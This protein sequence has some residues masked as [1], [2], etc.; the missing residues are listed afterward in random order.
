[1][2]GGGCWLLWDVT[3]I[4][5]SGCWLHP[6]VVG[7][8]AAWQSV[9]LRGDTAL[10]IGIV[11]LERVWYFSLAAVEK[12]FL[13]VVALNLSGAVYEARETLPTVDLTVVMKGMAARRLRIHSKGTV[14]GTDCVIPD[15][16]K[17][18]RELDS[19]NC[20]TFVQTSQISRAS[21]FTIVEHF[22]VAK[23]HVRHAAAIYTLQA[24]FKQYYKAFRNEEQ[25][26]DTYGVDSFCSQNADGSSQHS[27]FCS[28]AR[29]DMARKGHRRQEMLLDDIL[30][31]VERAKDAKHNGGGPSFYEQRKHLRVR[32]FSMGGGSLGL[33]DALG[34]EA[35]AQE[36]RAL[37]GDLQEIKKGQELAAK[38]ESDL[39]ARNEV[40]EIRCGALDDKLELVLS[41]L[42]SMRAEQ[43]RM[44]GQ[45]FAK[46]GECGQSFAKSFSV[47][48]EERSHV[49]RTSVVVA[50]DGS[51][52]EL[53]RRRRSTTKAIA[54]AALIG[55]QARAA[56]G[57]SQGAPANGEGES[58]ESPCNVLGVLSALGDDASHV[59][60]RAELREAL[61]A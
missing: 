36:F 14:L 46:A 33:D 51:G 1:M 12:E 17:N 32:G 31:S 48:P 8:R 56:S 3:N 6:N 60:E 57:A 42:T 47:S 21:L 52:Q 4:H 40:L 59:A 44:G 26:A 15:E 61:Q 10:K 43:Q 20:L 38:R 16:R 49:K 19:A 39:M 45:S 18:L 55:V 13:A 34:A 35:D 25:R 9:Q 53:R 41:L 27:S 30:Q 24:A 29:Y 11:T 50:A 54:K 7:L 37:R 22:P 28:R 23:A 58:S 2:G 5:N